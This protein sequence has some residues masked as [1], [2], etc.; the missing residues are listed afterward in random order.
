LLRRRYIFPPASPALIGI[1]GVSFHD[2]FGAVSF[3]GF[4][5]LGRR[6]PDPASLT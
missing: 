6:G 4:E 5:C 1:W 3:H 2:P